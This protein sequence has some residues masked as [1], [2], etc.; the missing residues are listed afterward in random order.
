MDNHLDIENLDTLLEYLEPLKNSECA[1]ECELILCHDNLDIILEVVNRRF[2]DS[3]N[4]LDTRVF[5]T[6]LINILEM[7]GDVKNALVLALG[8]LANAQDD[9]Q[10][11]DIIEQYHRDEVH[12]NYLKVTYYY[13]KDEVDICFDIIVDNN[14]FKKFPRLCYSVAVK[15]F[16]KDPYQSTI[17]LDELQNVEDNALS[18]VFLPMLQNELYEANKISLVVAVRNRT[19]NLVKCFPSWL[20]VD[21]IGEYIIVD[22]TSD[23]SLLDNSIV[24]SWTNTHNVK[25]IRV[26]DEKQFNL[27]KAYNLAF[28]YATYDNVLK[29][30]ADYINIDSSW[31][32][33]FVIRQTSSNYF[34]HGHFD[35]G[36][37]LSGLCLMRKDV[38]S[39]YREDLS[40]YGYDEVDMYERCKDKGAK[41]I[42]F[43]DASKYVKH[44]GH[45]TNSRSSDYN[46]K[47]IKE[48]ELF[49]R[50]LCQKYKTKK[51]LRSEY[52]IDN[53]IVSYEQQRVQN[54]LC[55]NL[56]KRTD[57]WDS[58]KGIHRVKRFSAVDAKSNPDIYKD[59]NL[60]LSPIDISSKLYFKFHTGAIGAFLSH[61]SVWKYIV[62]QDLDHTLV[63]EDDV[64][65][66]SVN[67]ILESNVLFKGVDF[68]QLSRRV[69]KINDKDVFDGGESYILS[70]TGAEKLINAV[71]FPL[72][73]GNISVDK[74][75]AVSSLVHDNKIEDP[76][77]WPNLPS[78]TCP[79]DK[80]MGYCC[81][82]AASDL[83][84]LNNIMYPFVKLSEDTST[85]SDINEASNS[86]TFSRRKVE[87][88][89]KNGDI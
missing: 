6:L 73:L 49:N 15:L 33:Q 23:E 75:T 29:I 48:S 54:V 7:F 17:I 47:N 11:F 2:V 63:I 62:E 85:L 40:G 10:A 81:Q 42:V 38:F 71:H 50:E 58:V 51:P 83:C 4:D 22:F 79:V 65:P 61:Y 74:F 66:L 3:T 59:F 78:I 31:L 8:I 24:M 89:I 32:K 16:A 18:G 36:F 39:T 43:F 5:L 35:F 44:L 28:D 70:K 57:R 53:N 12:K 13:G 1:Q 52:F 82:N 56:D 69:R 68:V 55:I 80:L 86:W 76:N 87:H 19:D 37:H 25:V 72:L 46:S 88:I 26:E 67:Y 27:G 14:L 60:Q 84:R 21:I 20:D 77:V 41:P 34:V 9:E 45:T 64:D 30:D